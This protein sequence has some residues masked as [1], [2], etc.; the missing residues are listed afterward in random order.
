M[1]PQGPHE[2]KPLLANPKPADYTPV[3]HDQGYSPML[4]HLAA[5][6]LFVA[7]SVP[8]SADNVQL[9]AD[10]PDRYT[11]VRGD[12]LW[13]IA[14][15]FLKDPWKWPSVWKINQQ[16]RNPHLIYPGDVIA[17]TWVDGQPQL[18]LLRNETLRDEGD[19]PPP[20]ATTRAPEGIPTV[21]LEPRAYPEAIGDAI[22]TIKPEAILPFLTQPLIV[23]KNDLDKAGYITIGRD[24]RVAL[25][26][27]SEFYARRVKGEEDAMF[28]VFRKGRT[29][30]DPESGELL[31]YEARYLGDAVLKRGGDPARLEVVTVKEEILP[32]DRL[33]AAPEGKSLPYFEPRAPEKQVKGHI[34]AAHN[35]LAE[36][37]PNT[38]V[39]VSI[40]SREGMEP[41]HVLR[42]SRHVGKHRDPVTKNMYTIPDEETGLLMIFRVFDK[43]SYGLIM[44]ADRPVQLNDVVATPAG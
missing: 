3:S 36:F 13:D 38:V 23:S 5:A 25:G 24:D 10:H 16:V 14:G 11:V 30:R 17:L 42:I 40:G 20:P 26:T 29:F 7:I 33:I 9:R 1:F 15:R 41:G 43:V 34:L 8:A 12:T 44:N 28:N 31:G 4:R 27:S 32:T 6:L 37:G 19:I 18:S 39:A 21:K 35:G 2:N 22:P